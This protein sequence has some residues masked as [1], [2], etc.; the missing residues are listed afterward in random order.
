M[1]AAVAVLG[2]LKGNWTWAVPWTLLAAVG[3]YAGLQHMEVLT[4]E[5]NA[6]TE[7]ARA[8]KLV[9]DAKAAD[10]VLAVKLVGEYAAEIAE[11]QEKGNAKQVSIASAARSDACLHTDAARA[12]LGSVPGPD[13]AGPGQSRPAA[14][15]DAKVPR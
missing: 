14:G 15:A 10:H 11:L 9:N 7:Q 1:G 5:K 13:K 6:A 2:F 4:L 8:E 3:L 12:F